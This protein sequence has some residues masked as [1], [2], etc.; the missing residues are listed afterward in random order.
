VPQ[1]EK[2]PEQYDREIAL[3]LAQ[4]DVHKTPALDDVDA[5]EAL[6]ADRKWFRV[7]SNKG[8]AKG[9]VGTEG[10]LAWVAVEGDPRAL[11]SSP[12][13]L[14]VSRVGLRVTGRSSYLFLNPRHVT[15]IPRPTSDEDRIAIEAMSHGISKVFH[16]RKKRR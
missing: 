14:K 7:T 2:T 16:L 8:N 15:L 4:R 6:Q 9:N 13:R 1:K 10:Q 11:G 5:W 12:D 3:A